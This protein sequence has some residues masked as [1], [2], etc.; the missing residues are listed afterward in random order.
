MRFQTVE[1]IIDWTA[2]FHGRLAELFRA[3][4]SAEHRERL[5]LLLQYVA[6]HEQ[7]LRNSLKN[8]ELDGA[9]R[10][11]ATWFDHAPEAD[12][13]N[14][15]DNI[16]T[17]LDSGDID[18]IIES[19]VGFHD[20]MIGAYANLREQANNDSIRT[21]FDRLADLEHNEKITLVRDSQHFNDI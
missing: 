14:V 9:D 6:D 19:V 10:L 5:S 18:K 1:E 4:S 12:L 21:L 8:F 16:N 15:P 2:D 20:R 13:P 17:L 3:A 11:L 7:H